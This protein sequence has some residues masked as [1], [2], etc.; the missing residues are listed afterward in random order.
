MNIIDLG[1]DI[2]N[3]IIIPFYEDMDIKTLKQISKTN[4]YFNNYIYGILHYYY[5][6]NNEFIK[7]MIENDVDGA[8]DIPYKISIYIDFHI[9]LIRDD[10]F[11]TY[12]LKKLLFYYM[13]QGN[14]E[15]IGKLYKELYQYG[16]KYT[17]EYI[18]FDLDLFGEIDEYMHTFKSIIDLPLED[19]ND[20]LSDKYL[21]HFAVYIN[22]EN[23]IDTINRKSNIS[24]IQHTLFN[25]NSTLYNELIDFPESKNIIQLAYKTAISDALYDIVK[26]LLTNKEFLKKHYNFKININDINNINRGRINHN[27]EYLKILEYL[28]SDEITEQYVKFKK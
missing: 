1:H 9:S 15:H 25:I 14:Y 23:F 12:H 4:K 3:M 28:H 17:I 11:G 16:H 20:M 8:N 10:E 13:Q 21:N 24:I 27:K 5:D 2:L 6:F 18:L 22:L 19:R 26:L 7:F